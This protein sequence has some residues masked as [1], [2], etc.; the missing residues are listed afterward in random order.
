MRLRVML[1]SSTTNLLMVLCCQI[2]V[3]TLGSKSTFVCFIPDTFILLDKLYVGIS[4]SFP[5]TENDPL[6]FLWYTFP[7]VD[8]Y[9]TW[10][11]QSRE[12]RK[13]NKYTSNNDDT[14]LPS[15]IFLKD[16]LH[17]AHYWHWYSYNLTLHQHPNCLTST[18]ASCCFLLNL[19]PTDPPAL[20]NAQIPPHSLKIFLNPRETWIDILNW[21][22][23]DVINYPNHC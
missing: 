4:S 2:L 10:L 20:P 21:F 8:H 5:L 16:I 23:I 1:Q 6:S 12:E 7:S 15:W 11:M 3:Q 9:L 18:P 14:S 19:F 17:T 13:L 22:L